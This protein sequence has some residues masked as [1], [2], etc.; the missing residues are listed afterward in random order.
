MSGFRVYNK[1]ANDLRISDSEYVEN[2]KKM[3]K[4]LK[5]IDDCLARYVQILEELSENLEGDFADK[6]NLFANNV[7]LFVG[8]IDA[9]GSEL[10]NNMEGYIREIDQADEKLY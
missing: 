7:K 10:N 2:G 1:Y 3:K 8:I 4:Q 9:I 5:K 6:M